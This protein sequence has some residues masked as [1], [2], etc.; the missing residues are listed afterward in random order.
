MANKAQVQSLLHQ[1]GAVLFRS[2]G[3]ASAEEFQNIAGVFCH[4][5]GDYIGGNSPRTKVMSHVFTSTEYPAEEKISLHNEASYLKRMPGSILFYCQKT[6]AT[7][8]Q[9][10]LADCRRVLARI[11]PE[12]RNRFNRH[13]VRYV[14]NLHGGA[15]LGRSWMQAYGVKDRNEVE[16]LLVEIWKSSLRFEKIGINDSFSDEVN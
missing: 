9:T 12:V 13:G 3:V 14:N 11:D 10:P 2:F 4:R 16:K 15:G 8:G 7:G 5:L 6:A 1:H